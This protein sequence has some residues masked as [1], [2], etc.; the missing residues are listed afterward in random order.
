VYDPNVTSFFGGLVGGWLGNQATQATRPGREDMAET[1][2]ATLEPWSK[3][4]FD[5]CKRKFRSFDTKDGKYT[6]FD[7]NR[8]FCK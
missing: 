4:W 7:G 1:D 8:Y 6:S 3:E 5:Y 2:E